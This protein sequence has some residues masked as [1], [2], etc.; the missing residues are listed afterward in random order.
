MAS[1]NLNKVIL[2][3]RLTATPDLK[4]TVGGISVCSFTVAINRRVKKEDEPVADFVNCIAWRQTAEFIC[5][6]FAKG[7]SIC[8]VGE[9][10]TRQWTDQAGQKRYAT[11]V[12]VDEAKFVDS[13]SE[14]QSTAQEAENCP[15]SAGNTP[16]PACVQTT[17]QTGFA[18]VQDDGDLP[19]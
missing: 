13:K 6:H 16:P 1:L 2:G 10:Q 9:L 12:R 8:I 15:V 18:A 17:L 7:A 11:E 4:Q 5:N 3:G 14:V 19:F